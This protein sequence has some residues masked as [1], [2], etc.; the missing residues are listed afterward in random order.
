MKLLSLCILTLITAVA[1]QAQTADLIL[2][3]ATIWTVDQKNPTAEAIA[4][5]DGKFLLVGS[6]I[7]ALKV[8]GPNTRIIDLKGSFVV[9]GFNDNHVHFASAAQ[10][11]EHARQGRDAS[12]QRGDPQKFLA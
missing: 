1:S 6:N 12:L 9:P 2:H 8:R 11:L 7:A 10:F 3:N 5:R 4:I